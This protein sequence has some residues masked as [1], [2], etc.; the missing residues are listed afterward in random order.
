MPV[1]KNNQRKLDVTATLAVPGVDCVVTS[2]DARRWTRPFAVAVKT[3][4]EQWCLAMDRVRHVGEPVYWG[5]EARLGAY[6]LQL[7]GYSGSRLKFGRACD[8][9]PSTRS[10]P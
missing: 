9:A 3:G 7:R 8:R 10:G 1:L 5:M 4:M 6:D 2:E